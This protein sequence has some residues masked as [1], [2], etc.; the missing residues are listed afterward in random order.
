M[1]LKTLLSAAMFA[2]GGTL[3]LAFLFQRHLSYFPD[4]LAF[5]PAE[6]AMPELETLTVN[7]SD[8]L[9]LKSWY[10]GPKKSGRP[11]IVFFQGNGAHS[12]YRNFKVRPW[13][14]DGY[15]L[16]FVGYRGYGGNPGKP[17]EQGLYN[18]ARAAI[19]AVLQR[20]VSPSSLIFYGESIGS[21]VA[22]QMAMEYKP[23][24]LVLEAPFTSLPDA[25]A[26]HYPWLPVRSF[27]KDKYDSLAKIGRVH[28]PL[29]LIHG[30]KDR[31][32]PIQ[33]GRQLFAAANEP[34]QAVYIPEAGHNDLY[35]WGAEEVVLK[36]LA[37]I[38]TL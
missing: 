5:I 30:E 31:I 8:G 1:T 6:W 3:V 35:D 9:N 2:Y 4:K 36:F 33:F 15:G 20:G 29:L 14:D 16:L 25:G 12:G 10:R 27:L 23:A 37:K 24:A 26:Y 19:G 17:S 7:T 32:V 18:D 13:L 34:K 28:A 21:G 38:Q 22:V 11:V